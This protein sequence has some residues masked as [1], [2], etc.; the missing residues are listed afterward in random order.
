LRRCLCAAAAAVALAPVV[1]LEGRVKNA[2]ETD[3]MVVGVTDSSGGTSWEGWGA[4]WARKVLENV[5]QSSWDMPT[6]Y[7]EINKDAPDKLRLNQ[8]KPLGTAGDGSCFF[9]A[10]VGLLEALGFTLPKTLSNMAEKKRFM[11]EWAAVRMEELSGA[12][13]GDDLKVAAYLEEVLEMTS[14]SMRDHAEELLEDGEASEADAIAI[15]SWFGV[16][17]EVYRPFK[18]EHVLTKVSAGHKLEEAGVTI[19]H[20]PRD[21]G[22]IWLLHGDYGGGGGD[23]GTR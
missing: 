8:A 16:G 23:I 19:P 18:G 14:E 6:E 20:I 13:D 17:V 1:A 4:Y 12:L 3:G 7:V 9:E 22:T 5:W 15:G 11:R 10:M 21:M 2:V